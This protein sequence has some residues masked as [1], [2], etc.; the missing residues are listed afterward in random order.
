MDD[1]P[2]AESKPITRREFSLE[3]KS[4]MSNVRLMIIASVA[5]NQFLA[6][7]QLPAE[8]AV[9]AVIAAILAPAAKSVLVFFGVR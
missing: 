5:L 4:F 8:V 2:D 9:P 6:N 1:Q 7:V 3:M